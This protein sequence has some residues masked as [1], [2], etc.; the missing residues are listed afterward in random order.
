MRVEVRQVIKARESMGEGDE[1]HKI[2]CQLRL[3]VISYHKYDTRL[4]LTNDRIFV[5]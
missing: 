2:I 5:H 3:S 4:I 1:S